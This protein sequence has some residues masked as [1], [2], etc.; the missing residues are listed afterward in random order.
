L[1]APLAQNSLNA[2]LVQGFLRAP[3]A[4]RALHDFGAGRP[5]NSR[6]A[7]MAAIEA[8]YG[9]EIDVQM[10]RDGA[11]MVLHDYDLARL[12]GVAGLVADST[13]EALSGLP[14]LGGAEGI[15]ALAEVLALVAGRAPLLV[16]L[17]DQHGAMGATD[18]RLERAVARD[19]AGYDGP[20]AVMSFNP[21]MVLALRDLAPDVPRGIVT[22]AYDPGDVDWALLPAATRDH[23]REIAEYDAAGCCFISHERHDLARPRVAQLKAQGAAVL[24]WTARSPA[25]EEEAR[26]VADNITFEGYLAPLPG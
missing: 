3:L 10:S 25:Q 22:S 18:G 9:I 4:H 2:P 23:L 13:S 14:L 12:T 24:A 7:I 11:A 16:E 8:G 15:P 17:K 21:S 19:I 5:E 1:G 20:L 6:S 26:R